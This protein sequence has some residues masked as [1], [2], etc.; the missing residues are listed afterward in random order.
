MELRPLLFKPTKYL[1]IVSIIFVTFLAQTL[2]V[3]AGFG[4]TPPYIKNDRLTRESS[5]QQKIIL[6]RG[7]PEEDMKAEITMNIPGINGW[8]SVDKGNEFILPKGEKQV[9]IIVSVTV[10]KDADYDDYAGSI[11]IRT[12][13]LELPTGGGVSIALGA[14][15]DVDISVVDKVLDFNVRKVKM[16]DLEEGHKKWSLFFP[17]KINFFMTVENTGND[18]FGPTKVVLDIYDS[19]SETLLETIENRN[20][21]KSVS[22][23][24]IEEVVAEFATR[25]KSGRYTAKYTI[26]KQDK[27]AQQGSVNLSISPFGSIPGNKGYAMMAL[28]LQ[29]KLKVASVFGSVLLVFTILIKISVVRRRKRSIRRRAR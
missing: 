14:Q 17:G 16:S 6:V 19:Q 13:P 26:F 11:R 3:S 22:P 5:Y 2:S 27:I 1:I 29:D 23:F 12:S 4:I 24:G 7:D 15:V 10:P 20:K 18:D 21:I 28:S 8:F 9:P 25:L